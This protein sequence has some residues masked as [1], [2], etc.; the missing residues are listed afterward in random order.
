MEYRE[1]IVETTSSSGAVGNQ[2]STVLKNR[3]DYFKHD[4]FLESMYIRIL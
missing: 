1:S 4:L 2:A 3:G